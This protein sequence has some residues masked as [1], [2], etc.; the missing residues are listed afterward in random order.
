[1]RFI[2]G[3]TGQFFRQ[4]ALTIAVSTRDLGLQLADAQPGP[5]GLAAASR[6]QRRMS[7]R[8]RGWRLSARRL[9][10]L[11]LAWGLLLPL[12]GKYHRFAGAGRIARF[13]RYSL[14]GQC[15]SAGSLSRP[16]NWLLG[17]SFPRVQ[18]RFRLRPPP[19]TRD[20]VGGLLRVSVMVLLVY[21]GLLWS[22]YWSFT[23]TPTGFIPA[24]GQGLFAG[25]RAV[26]R[27]RVARADAA[28]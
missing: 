18:P 4:F 7:R 1:M 12:V 9:A 23:Q 13:W 27:C 15:C 2:A 24:A 17:W 3:I 22:D 28:R 19:A 5:G 20:V 26:A 10:G 6:G 8:C 11:E 16:L 21:G 25:Q 14:A